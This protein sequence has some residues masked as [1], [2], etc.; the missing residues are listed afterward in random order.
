MKHDEG[1]VR[2]P[3]L[4]SLAGMIRKFGVWLVPNDRSQT[5]VS[6]GF[7]FIAGTLG[8]LELWYPEPEIDTKFD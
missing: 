7:C 3:Y 4:P 8:D 5:K 1:V 2:A 6:T